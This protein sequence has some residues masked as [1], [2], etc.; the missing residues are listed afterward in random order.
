VSGHT[1]W[2]HGQLWSQLPYVTKQGCA[3]A[4]D[5]ECSGYSEY[6]ER[7]QDERQR[8]RADFVGGGSHVVGPQRPARFNAGP[9]QRTNGRR[10]GAE[11]PAHGRP[12]IG[13]GREDGDR[14]EIS[15]QLLRREVHAD[16]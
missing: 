16:H 12:R 5:K 4:T 6:G 2:T 10:A 14:P 7:W 9:S 13:E 8:R 15:E 3:A 11:L 1:K